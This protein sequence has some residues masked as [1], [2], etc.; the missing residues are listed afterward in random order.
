MLGKLIKH[1]FRA[2]RRTMLPMLIVFAAGSALM[3]IMVWFDAR[4]I[5]QTPVGVMDGLL[6]M[7]AVFTAMVMML[8]GILLATAA[9][10]NVFV[11]VNRFHKNIL[12]D[13]GYLTHTLPVTTEQKLLSKLIV[14]MTWTVATYIIIIISTILISFIIN[15]T[16]II[17]LFDILDIK[18]IHYVIKGVSA[19]VGFCRFYLT[20]F[21]AMSIGY[22]FND[23]RRAGSVAIAVGICIAMN[24]V[25][26]VIQAIYNWNRVGLTVLGIP[27]YL[28]NSG[29]SLELILMA[30]SMIMCV[31]LFFVT[32]YFLEKRL[33]LQ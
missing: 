22:S 3:P 26:S 6:T 1:E 8:Y 20:I 16:G 21:A 24:V 13:E 17:S 30:A 15:N 23:H 25:E 29:L 14:D 9:C 7:M 31:V 12:G 19:I 18:G 5:V 2:T 33:N 10:M 28:D 4:H 32:R 27:F 11:A